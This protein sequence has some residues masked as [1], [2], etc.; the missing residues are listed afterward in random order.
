MITFTLSS[1]LGKPLDIMSKTTAVLV[2]SHT[3]ILS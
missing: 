1:T 3:F 2:L